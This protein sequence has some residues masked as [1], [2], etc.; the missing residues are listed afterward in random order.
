MEC[1]AL[2]PSTQKWFR[3][4]VATDF[5]YGDLGRICSPCRPTIRFVNIFSGF[6]GDL[7]RTT[8]PRWKESGFL[9]PYFLTNN[10]SFAEVLNAGFKDG[11]IENP[12]ISYG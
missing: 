10:I 5:G 3:G 12:R 4:I 11:A 7:K 6:D 9:R 2:S 1:I 8:S